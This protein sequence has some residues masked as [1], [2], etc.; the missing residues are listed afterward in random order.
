[1]AQLASIGEEL[2]PSPSKSSSLPPPPQ[3]QLLA[4]QPPLVHYSPA[5]S[6]SFS[7]SSTMSTSPSPTS[8]SFRQSGST[9]SSTS[10]SALG[11]APASASTQLL[12]HVAKPPLSL[13]E[14]PQ[15]SP[16]A[17][18]SAPQQEGYAGYSSQAMAHQ[19][20]DP[21]AIYTDLPTYKFPPPRPLSSSTS[22]SVATTTPKRFSKPGHLQLSANAGQPTSWEEVEAGSPMYSPTVSHSAGS[23][24]LEPV[25]QVR[26]QPSLPI[27]SLSQSHGSP[28][29]AGEFEESHVRSQSMPS[30]MVHGLAKST[31]SEQSFDGRMSITD[32]ARSQSPM[33]LQPLS[34]GRTQPAQLDGLGVTVTPPRSTAGG[35]NSGLLGF[36]LPGQASHER[37]T[38]LGAPSQPMGY[39]YSSTTH[40]TST[41]VP[42][43]AYLPSRSQFGSGSP[44]LAPMPMP[45]S[46]PS[47]PLGRQDARFLSQ[48]RQ[49][50][51]PQP[52]QAGFAPP[53][54]SP[55]F[56]PSP[57]TGHLAQS[58]SMQSWYSQEDY[59]DV[60]PGGSTAG[61]SSVGPGSGRFS[62]APFGRDAESPSMSSLSKRMSPF[63]L[64]SPPAHKKA[65]KLVERQLLPKIESPSKRST[66]LSMS[67][68]PSSPKSEAGS[69]F[70]APSPAGSTG[71]EKPK[72]A[73]CRIA[74]SECRK[75]RLKCKPRSV[76]ARRGWLADATFR[77]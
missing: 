61:Y 7:T 77:R 12:A 59:Y 51:S 66:P 76:S 63:T 13:R 8:Y 68:G 1:M 47:T 57:H 15:D 6:F 21:E 27:I 60:S 11:A 33:Q 72:P 41:F 35:G 17:A 46:A 40:T 52:L 16:A 2:A 43:S 38:S 36:S 20:S 64:Q 32:D 4:A 45:R 22:S 62:P 73:R 65:K 55:M 14:V 26:L 75:T 71:E 25:R 34:L 3:P 24:A 30:G 49:H 39:H 29:L 23:P 10:A 70:N 18:T 58:P 48:M 67:T 9:D 54:G 37:T 19:P 74:C 28:S 31:S 42:S 50:S 56:L 53:A 44:Q 69:A 5:P